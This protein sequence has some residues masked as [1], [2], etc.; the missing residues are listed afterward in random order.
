VRPR[1]TATARAPMRPTWLV[2]PT[3]SAERTAI[4]PPLGARLVRD[5]TDR[6]GPTNRGL[7]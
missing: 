3:T 7:P 4:P 6:V 1:P 2:R 5:V